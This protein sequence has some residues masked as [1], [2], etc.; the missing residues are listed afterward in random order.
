MKV[1]NW[2]RSILHGLGA[3]VIVAGLDLLPA[4][5]E[6]A[7][8]A[9]ATGLP[10]HFG[11]GVGASPDDIGPSGWTTSTG[12]PFDYVFQYL[13]AGVNTGYGWETWNDRG[14]F[15]LFY[16]TTAS[17]HGWLPVFTYYEIHASNGPCNSCGESQKD[18]GNLAS[19]ST[20][21]AYYQNF[22]L[23]MKRLGPATVDGIQGFSKTAI[24]HVEPDLSGYAQSAARNDDPATV[25]ASVASSGVADVAAYPDT[26]QG[27]NWALL[28]LRDLY[29]PNVLL[30]FHVS[31]W[32]GGTDVDT[33]SDPR[34]DASGL[35]AR[36]GL[37][38]ARS[39]VAQ[40]PS[41]TSTYDLIFND[42]A[43]RD[44]GYS[45]YV[46][47]DASRWW[48]RLNVTYPN[49]QRWEQW[50]SAAV[51]AAGGKP[52]MVWQVPLGNQYF[53]SENNADGH[54][55]DNRIEYFF[56]HLSELNQAGIVGLLFGAGNGGSTVENDGKK[57]GVTN[58]PAM[59]TTDGRS[60]GQVCNNHASSVSDDDGGYLR[61]AARAY[62]AN[63]M[64][65]GPAAV[66]PLPAPPPAETPTP[67]PA[68]VPAPTVRVDL[69][70][71]AV[72]PDTATA[73][74]GVTLRQDVL[75]NVDSVLLI[76]FEVYDAQGNKA[77][78]AWQDD[79]A[80]SAGLPG[81]VTAVLTVPD[82]LPPGEYLLKTGAYSPGWGTLYAWSDHAGL[83]TV[84]P[85]DQDS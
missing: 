84:L 31:G 55:Q 54:F 65:L 15:P 28:H 64:P 66:A 80:F 42:V 74:T 52:A 35:G 34:L 85:P 24:V 5:S 38:A 6:Q 27:F 46:L 1:R 12:I 25:E 26:Y 70:G 73:G 17:S 79:V 81:S 77:W 10:T 51:Q 83:L 62:F 47:K 75:T 63:P 40:S 19:P 23:L 36:V 49:F 33:S 32:A 76:D 60:S 14:Q 16:A 9:D 68:P 18:L 58:P 45:K 11:I 30:A 4:G 3:L 21:A 43:D 48:D 7:V 41:G 67:A 72:Q 20:M 59:C 50:L 22:A 82:S 53:Q 56:E 44:A 29:A 8:H 61:M 2:R 71:G 78:Q 13:S 37:F 57:D 39:G 69:L